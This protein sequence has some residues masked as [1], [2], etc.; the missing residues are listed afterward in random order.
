MSLYMFS[1]VH[2][3]LGFFWTYCGKLTPE[4]DQAFSSKE[5][6]GPVRSSDATY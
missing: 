3:K 1:S 2:G 6:K 4:C 5:R